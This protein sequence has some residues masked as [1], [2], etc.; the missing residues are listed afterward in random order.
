MIYL[1]PLAKQFVS[2]DINKKKDQQRIILLYIVM[3]KEKMTPLPTVDSKEIRVKVMSEK[4]LI[5]SL[6]L[7]LYL[8]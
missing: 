8:E 2:R 5:M 6:V 1:L 3:T 4:V 7:Y